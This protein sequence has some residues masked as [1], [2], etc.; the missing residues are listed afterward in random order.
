MANLALN[1][2]PL[3]SIWIRPEEATNGRTTNYNGD[4]GFSYAPFPATYTLDLGKDT[5]IH[6]IRFLL[7]DGINFPP[8][9]TSDTRQYFYSLSL[10]NDKETWDTY[11]STTERGYNGWQVFELAKSIQARFVRIQAKYN[12]AGLDFHIVEFEVHDLK[13]G[14]IPPGSAVNNKVFLIEPIIDNNLFVKNLEKFIKTNQAALLEQSNKLLGKLTDDTNAATKLKVQLSER[15]E[16]F[17]K[18]NQQLNVAGKSL[19]FLDEAAKIKATSKKWLTAAI[20]SFILF[21]GLIFCFLFCGSY[22]F[23]EISFIV[24]YSKMNKELINETVLFEFAS[25]LILKALLVSLSIYAVV[26][27][28]K[29][30][31][32]QMHNY[33]INQHKAMS[34]SASVQLLDNDKL[35]PDIR[36]RILIEATTTIF[37]HQTSGYNTKDSDINPNILAAALEKLK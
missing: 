15:I 31:R 3:E 7:W 28:A 20:V 27:C 33:T 25:Y 19:H 30:Y 29:N 34:L 24:S 11:Y 17:E 10:S 23:K 22:H 5:P 37:A 9:R 36:E 32:T 14:P 26:F 4:K 16:E 13:P 8:Q 35:N 1:R 18:V 2:V 12:T 6:T 21:L